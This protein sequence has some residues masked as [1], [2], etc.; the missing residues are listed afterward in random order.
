MTKRIF[1][2]DVFN[3]ATV[4][5]ALA[6]HLRCPGVAVVTM[7][8]VHGRDVAVVT[9]DPGSAVAGVDALV[10]R[11]P[12]LALLA[13]GADCVPLLLAD[14]DAGVVGAV[15]SGWRGVLADVTGAAIE[16]MV[17][18]GADPARIPYLAKQVDRVGSAMAWIDGELDRGALP[19]GALSTTA[20]A[21]VTALACVADAGVL[22]VV[23]HTVAPFVTTVHDDA[24]PSG[25]CLAE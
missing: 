17:G 12:G 24:T 23:R 10:T 7:A 2:A 5:R 20:I 11:V 16:A 1:P 14:D 3:G 8:P 9:E 13:L 4:R 21:L 22:F 6:E 25:G 19:E 15:H 18:L